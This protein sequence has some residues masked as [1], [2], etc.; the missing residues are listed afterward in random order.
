MKSVRVFTDDPITDEDKKLILT[1][2]IQAPSAGCQLLYTILDITDQNKK[3]RLADLCDHQTF[4]A[5]GQMVLIFCADCQKWDAFYK[6]AGISPRR[7]GAGDLLLQGHALSV[8]A[9]QQCIVGDHRRVA[10]QKARRLCAVLPIGQTDAVRKLPGGVPQEIFSALIAE[11]AQHK[12]QILHR[13]DGL[14]SAEARFA[15][16]VCEF[17]FVG[18]AHVGLCPVGNVSKRDVPFAAF[19]LCFLAE[20]ADEHRHGFRSRRRTVQIEFWAAIRVLSCALEKAQLVERLRSI[21]RLRISSKRHWYE[22]EQQD[23]RQQQ[24][25]DSPIPFHF[26]FSPLFDTYSTPDMLEAAETRL[27]PPCGA[28]TP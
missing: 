1:S 17:A 14:V 6:E 27:Y 10:A 23:E 22:P 7:P 12:R 4:I 19:G 16:A 8:G 25:H 3:D 15:H 20:Q 21:L 24:T 9:K 5:A 2:A 13:S 28:Y 18:V 26:H 11:R